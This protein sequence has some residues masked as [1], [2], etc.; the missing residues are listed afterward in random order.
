MWEKELRI[1]DIP[2]VLNNFSSIGQ[3]NK[4]WIWMPTL[5]FSSIGQLNKPW[6]WMPTLVTVESDATVYVEAIQKQ[7][8]ADPWRI[9]ILIANT[10]R[11]A[12]FS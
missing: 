12:H 3:L 11:L 8:R 1:Y 7:K 5:N 10:I 9:F 2:E 6:I 4:P